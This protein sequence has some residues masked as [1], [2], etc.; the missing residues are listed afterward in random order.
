MGCSALG[1]LYRAVSNAEAHAT[2]VRA[3]EAGLRYFDTAP[4]YGFG[5]AE[6]RLGAT[7]A[8]VTPAPD[9]L[10]STKVGRILRPTH[11]T[12]SREGFV[13]ALPFEAAFDYTFEGVMSSHDAS[14]ERLRHS[15][16]NLLLAH[17]LGARTHGD[18][19]ARM[20]ADFLNGGYA[21]M[22]SLRARGQVDAIGIGVNET[23]IC[24]TLLDRVELDVI[25]LAGRYTLL[26]QGGLDLLNRCARLGV[27][28]I[29]GGP[30]NSGL[31]VE[32]S[33]SPVVHYDYGTAPPAVIDT[34][35]AL[36]SVCAQF[37]VSLPAAALRFA[38][39]HPAVCCVLPGL[40][41][42]RQIEQT[43][44][45]RDQTIPPELWVAL[46]SAGLIA[47]AAPVPAQ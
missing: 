20:T 18:A 4:L 24:E 35:R 6:Q 33:D 2:L 7:L 43:L 16:V 19:S 14:L 46:R 30:F 3:L 26:E 45:W 38:A 12:G 32:A 15:K 29:I 28:V 17:D 47:A 23:E 37:G 42:A 41:S 31:L 1:N 36:R 13:D 9:V 5:L 8:A 22:R 34:V 40:A 10:I 25:L 21:A 11:A 27:R 44:A 39:A